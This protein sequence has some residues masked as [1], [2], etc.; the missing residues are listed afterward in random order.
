MSFA[1][2]QSS[3]SHTLVSEVMLNCYHTMNM[4][5]NQTAPICSDC[6]GKLHLLVLRV[7]FQFLTISHTPFRFWTTVCSRNKAQPLVLHVVSFLGTTLSPTNM[8]VQRVLLES[9]FCWQCLKHLFHV[10][11]RNQQTSQTVRAMF[12][13]GLS[14]VRPF[15]LACNFVKGEH[16]KQ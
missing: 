9:V 15:R 3:N 6:F 4:D 14:T 7:S 10:K 8:K 1:I 5:T 16:G 2:K 13:T 11:L 12:D